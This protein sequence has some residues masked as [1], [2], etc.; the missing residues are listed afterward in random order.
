MILVSEERIGGEALSRIETTTFTC[1]ICRWTLNT[2]FGREDVEVHSTLHN[3]IHHNK[4][5]RMNKSELI[6]MLSNRR[7]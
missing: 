7:K 2:P 5:L 6:Q 3:E 1:P 4:S